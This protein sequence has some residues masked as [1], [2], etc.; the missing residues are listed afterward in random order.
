M[1]KRVRNTLPSCLSFSLTQTSWHKSSWFFSIFISWKP[2]MVQ[3]WSIAFLHLCVRKRWS[4]QI[5]AW[6]TLWC[7]DLHR[8]LMTTVFT[9]FEEQL[10]TNHL[11]SF[12]PANFTASFVRLVNLPRV[13]YGVSPFRRIGISMLVHSL[14]SS[15]DNEPSSS[16]PEC[17]VKNSG[18][19]EKSVHI[20]ENCS[21]ARNKR[22]NIYLQ[23]RRF[24]LKAPLW[25]SMWAAQGSPW[26]SMWCFLLQVA[27]TSLTPHCL[28]VLPKL[29]CWLPQFV[30]SFELHSCTRSPKPTVSKILMSLTG[31]ILL[32]GCILESMQPPLECVGL[33]TSPRGIHNLPKLFLECL[34]WRY[35]SI[36]RIS[37]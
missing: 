22:P 13:W 2:N 33:S 26:L 24:L 30:D 18:L 4:I 17:L 3:K 35:C 28:D 27:L 10:V 21:W 11:R 16:F 37:V 36:F 25:L 8:F 32:P 15:R 1:A 7:F 14:Y 6:V 34:V 9:S 5:V 12:W 23:W 31:P 29:R 20:I 19:F